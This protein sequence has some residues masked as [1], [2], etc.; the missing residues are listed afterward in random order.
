MPGRPAR[1]AALQPASGPRAAAPSRMAPG[2][3]VAGLLLLAAGLG[4]AAAGPALAFSEDVLSVFGANRSLSAAQL[5]RLLRELG[6]GGAEGG[7]RPAQLHFNQVG[8][9]GKGGRERVLTFLHAGGGGGG[10]ACP[11]TRLPGRGCG[12]EPA[13]NCS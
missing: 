9:V 10:A 8:R 11:Q 2:R 3:A 12:A 13:R 4:G 6:A 5:A 7:P 1:P